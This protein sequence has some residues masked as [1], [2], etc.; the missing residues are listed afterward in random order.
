MKENFSENDQK[1]SKM[2]DFSNP[3]NEQDT[4][5]EDK[6]GKLVNEATGKKK[7]TF[8]AD[9]T[10]NIQ[11]FYRSKVEALKKSYFDYFSQNFIN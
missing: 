11:Q 8:S 5:I 3:L 2:G 9:N 7:P 6:L 1:F 10:D 4:E